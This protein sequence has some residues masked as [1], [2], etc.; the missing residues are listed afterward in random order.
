MP[1]M[2]WAAATLALYGGTAALAFRIAHRRVLP[3][4]LRAALVLGALP[5]LFTGRAILT[6]GILAP[7][8]VAYEAEPL[9]AIA[10]EHGFG[11]TANPLLV[12]LVSQ[13]LPWR[14]AVRDCLAQGRLPVWN[15]HVLGG[16]P[17]LGVAQPAVL[18]PASVIGLGLPLAQAW[19][20]DLSLRMLIALGSAFL[21]FRGIDSSEVPSLLGA[22]AWAF[23]DF[24]IFFLGYPVT[25]SVAPFPLLA[26]GLL[27]LVEA[28]GRRAVG[29]TAA[30]LVLTVVAGHPET[31][32]FSGP[33]RD[34]SSWRSSTA[35]GKRRH[36]SGTSPATASSERPGP[37]RRPGFPTARRA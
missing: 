31:L 36:G 11:K 9:H 33:V 8:D 34:S 5:L 30:A 12:D 15:P 16:E 22:L 32:L 18:H 28:P 20:F 17:L 26:L 2:L 25:P 19:N 7:L 27:R 37:T 29:L 1:P 14:Q 35:A 24:L 23:S 10:A 21:F 4:S 3:V 6:G 13:M